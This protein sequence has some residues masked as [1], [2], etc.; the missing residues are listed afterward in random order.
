[1]A[2]I[3]SPQNIGITTSCFPFGVNNNSD[4]YFIL[5]RTFDLL[6]LFEQRESLS[7]LLAVFQL[8]FVISTRQNIHVLS[9]NKIAANIWLFLMHIAGAC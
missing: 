1:V 3:H 4:Q 8:H 7:F 6:L 9:Q 5:L 2:W